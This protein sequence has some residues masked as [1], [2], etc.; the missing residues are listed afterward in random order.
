[1]KI[2]RL[3]ILC[4][5]LPTLAFGA[6][7]NCA[8][9]K[10]VPTGVLDLETVIELGLCRNPETASSYYSYESARFNKNAGYASY[11]PSLDASAN[12]NKS[13]QNHDWHDWKYGAS[14]SASYLIFDFGR[15]LADVNRLNSVWRATG[16]EYDDRVQNYVY[17][18]IGA[19][20][21]LLNADADVESAR[22][23]RAV[24][25]TALDTANKKFKAGVVAKAD[26]LKAETTMASRDLDLERAKNNREIAKGTLL[27]KLSF[28]ANQEIT[29]ADMPAEFGSVSEN[30][31]IDELIE[32]AREK[33]PDLLRASANQ[34]AA[35]HRRSAAFLKNLPSISATGSLSWSDNNDQYTGNSHTS[36]TIGIRA[37]MPIFAGFANMYGLRS[38]DAEYQAAKENL[39]NTRDTAMLDVFTAYQ[40]YKTAQTVLG[41][42]ETLLKS[43]TESEKVT[44]GMYKVGRATM[45]DWQTA[46]SELVS[47]QRQN[48]AA[49]YDLFTKRAAVALAIGDIK[50]EIEKDKK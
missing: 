36:G 39:R 7:E 1:M 16:F 24:A 35:W 47:A 28:P 41:Q 38:A 3:S 34:D 20:Y 40:N 37:S 9:L 22:S 5:F 17:G 15:R 10:T 44:A 42:T 8:T 25:K 14:L 19:Y 45:L 4:V 33:R 13:Y 21:S 2:S 29:I 11:L 31:T 46:Q 6:D 23:L 26:V 50:S 32:I 27:K 30:A 43:A 18:V 48:N 49:K 12:M